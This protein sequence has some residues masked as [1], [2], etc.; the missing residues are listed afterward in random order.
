MFERALFRPRPA[1][2][3]ANYDCV[4]YD[5]LKQRAATANSSSNSKSSSDFVPMA[6]SLVEFAY[7]YLGNTSSDEEAGEAVQ[8][9]HKIT[10]H[11]ECRILSGS[12]TRPTWVCAGSGLLLLLI[13]T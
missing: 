3:H 5:A 8:A 12:F 11:S 2:T 7:F 6:A 9:E 4:D 10:K 13:P 1:F